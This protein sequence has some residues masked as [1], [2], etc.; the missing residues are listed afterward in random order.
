MSV[1]SERLDWHSLRMLRHYVLI[2]SLRFFII[3]ACFV[4][5]VLSAWRPSLKS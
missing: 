3:A 1:Q 2:K 4:L 5:S